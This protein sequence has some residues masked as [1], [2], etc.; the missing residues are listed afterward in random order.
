MARATVDLSVQQIGEVG[1]STTAGSCL[2][3]LLLTFFGTQADAPI[4]LETHPV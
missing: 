4:V 3:I 1:C 2:L